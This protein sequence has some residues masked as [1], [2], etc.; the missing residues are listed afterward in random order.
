VIVEAFTLMFDL[1]RATEE[2]RRLREMGWELANHDVPSAQDWDAAVA[3]LHSLLAEVQA[4]ADQLR[5]QREED[6]QSLAQ[7]QRLRL[8]CRELFAFAPDGWLITDLEGIIEEANFA[9]A[10]LFG[11]RPDFLTDKPLGLLV[12]EAHRSTFYAHLRALSHGREALYDWH[13][14]LRPLRGAGAHVTVFASPFADE[15]GRCRSL[16]WLLRDVTPRVRTEEALASERGFAAAVVRAAPVIILSLDADGRVVRANPYLETVS[17]Q[18][19]LDVLGRPWEFLLPDADRATAWMLLRQTLE[20]GAGQ[21][22]TTGLLTRDGEARVVEWCSEP[23]AQGPGGLPEMLMIGHD[24]TELHRAQQ[25]AVQAERLATIGQ[26]TA[27]LAHEGRN[28]L[29]RSLACLERLG[30]RLADRPEEMDLLRRARSAQ[31]DLT[32]LFDDVR[33]Y[34]A[35]MVLRL[36]PCHLAEV[37]REA[38]EQA[39]DAFPGRAGRLTER[40]VG[41]NLWCNVDRHRLNQVFRNIFENAFSACGEGTQVDVLCREATLNGGPALALAVRDNGPGLGE[42]QKGRIFE[43]FYTTRPEG[44]GLGMAIARRIVEAHGGEIS[45]DN[46]PQGGAEITITLPRSGS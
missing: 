15:A 4:E 25:H 32:H 1:A 31:G 23:L 33:L 36:Q 3:R 45:A 39:G 21:R 42:E 9:A 28:A 8:R 38:W 13:I 10:S 17:G 14:R 41:V 22:G 44:T 11:T 35:P 26:V 20:T 18:A 29:Q 12:S 16:S 30:W 5:Q 46:A 6:E 40:S 27:S 24:I 2:A 19:A 37:W 43:P 34:A 7:L